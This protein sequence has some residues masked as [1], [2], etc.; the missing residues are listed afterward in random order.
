M[1]RVIKNE[2]G[3]SL[4][5][6]AIILVI[7]GILMGAILKGQAI[8][9]SAKIKRLLFD[10]EGISAA[11]NTYY[12]RYN[13]APGDDPNA[14]SRWWWVRNGSGDGFISGSDCAGNPGDGQ[15]CN[16]AW[17]AMRAALLLQGNSQWSGI[18]ALPS[19]GL[20]GKFFLYHGNFGGTIGQRNYIGVTNLPGGVGEEIDRKLDDGVWNAGS[21]LASGGYTNSLVHVYVAL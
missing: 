17:Q 15:E 9:E 18:Q 2:Q 19:P 21:V 10:I 14:S 16:E 1:K 5:E 4:V 12:G 13:A 6:L 20:G 7:I 11:Y 8:V 3:F